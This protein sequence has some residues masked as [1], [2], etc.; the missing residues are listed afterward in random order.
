[1]DV[2]IAILALLIGV[3]AI[4]FLVS[5]A[6]GRRSRA[7]ARARAQTSRATP[8]TVAELTRVRTAG[9]EVTQVVV[10]RQTEDGRELDRIV[11]ATVSDNAADWEE[12]MIEART[13]AATRA[14]LLNDQP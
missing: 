2:V 14:A 12:Q 1:M 3:A 4:T 10:R 9:R 11:V 13:A 5:W 8:W 7:E 6:A